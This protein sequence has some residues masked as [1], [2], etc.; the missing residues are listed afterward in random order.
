MSDA[1]NNEMVQFT[2]YKPFGQIRLVGSALADQVLSQ[3]QEGDGVVYGMS[4]PATQYVVAGKIVDLPVKPGAHHDFDYS[5]KQWI[6]NAESAWAA[7]RL[8][9]DQLMSASDW[10]VARATER[11]ELLDQQWKSYR[12]ALRDIT[13]QPDPSNIQW[14]VEPVEGA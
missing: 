8:R 7:I 13:E 2:L 6:F 9:R 1:K 3:M 10:R 14:P 5:A 12:Q 11:S 4:D